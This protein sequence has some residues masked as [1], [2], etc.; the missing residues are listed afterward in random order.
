MNFKHNLYGF[1]ILLL[2][3][4]RVNYTGLISL[5]EIVFRSSSSNIEHEYNSNRVLRSLDLEKP[6]Q[7]VVNLTHRDQKK[8]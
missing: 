4:S 1:E 5:I 3:L 2:S 6:W 8:N 7:K